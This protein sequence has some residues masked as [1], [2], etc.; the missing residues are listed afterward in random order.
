MKSILTLTWANIKHGRG[1]FKG[2]I[3]LM[4][5]IT[6][7]FAGT[8]SN[9]DRLSESREEKFQQAQVADLMVRLYDEVLTDD[10]L[11]SVEE[12]EYVKK[13]SVEQA[14][15]FQASGRLNGEEKDFWLSV[16]PRK[17]D[18]RVFA[19]DDRHFTDDISLKNG[20]I[21]LPYK[22]KLMKGFEPGA[23]I[24]LK[25]HSGFD[26]KFII[27]GYYEDVVNGATTVGLNYCAI[28]QE[29]F[30]RIKA[31]KT[32]SIYG[33]NCC[34]MLVD[35]VKIDAAD[36]VSSVELRRALGRDTSL[37]SSSIAAYTKENLTDFIEMYSNVGTRTVAIF[38]VLLLSVILIT[39]YNSISASIEMEYTELGILKSQG[40]TAGQISL[41][42][43]FQYTL[44][45]V[46]GGILGIV[47]SVPACYYMIGAWKKITGIMSGTGV[48]FLK[49]G[50]L[51]MG[52]ILICVVFILIAT[53]RIS[54][55]SPVRAISGGS[56]DVH[57]DSR[58]NVRIRKKPM[59]F[60]LALR[61][62]NSRRKSYIGTLF[63]VALLVYF[64][65]SIMILTKG[66]DTEAL[67]YQ[68]EGEISITNKNGLT[69][70][71]IDD[72]QK[73]IQKIDSGASIESE[74]FRYM[75]VDGE[76]TPVH[77]I[78][79]GKEVYKPM[80]G[81]V[82]K[83][84]NEI[85]ITEAVSE[86]IDKEIGDTLTVKYMDKE[87]EFVITGYFQAIWD[88]GL[89]TS[90][91]LDGMERIG[92][93]E[94]SSAYVKLS[95][96]SK[97]DEIIDMLNENYSDKFEATEYQDSEVI[98]SYEKVVNTLMDSIT[99]AMYVVLLTFAVVI[100]NMV[101]KRTFIRER[102]DIGIF[103]AVGFTVDSLRMQ[104][105]VRFTIVAVIGAALGCGLSMVWSRKMLTYILRVVGL[106]DFTTDYS[107]QTFIIPALIV[108]LCFFITSYIASH[109][110]K[111]V[112]VRELIT[113]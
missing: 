37:I 56:S 68:I 64:I 89:V 100:V 72:I 32:D 40:F 75:L 45:L 55:I 65:V 17:D 92:Y 102:T 108:S 24:E 97:R 81:R 63:I 71:N 41:A 90:V 19:D 69:L 20:E 77:Y 5:L 84:D 51:C 33:D 98:Q 60:F 79:A 50:A 91:T 94:I 109:R 25:T 59:A 85:M 46:I 78:R 8:V 6:F 82:P 52:I 54:K 99:I 18:I 49:C 66:L 27:K 10:M 36:G 93:N 101:C 26:E 70:D 53:S 95:D 23:E 58:L 38:V 67:F 107:P 96:I 44:A 76:M 103:K 21:F 4:M 83:Y 1:S 11:K 14:V 105:A 80:K 16:T 35:W 87:T 42:Y 106:T 104:F 29:D 39:M 28:T 9:D 74:S 111:T 73:E 88:F 22:M 2:I 112:E 3:L 61:Q 7:S 47:V 31:E 12:N 62:L 30:D 13:V 43:I 34:A 48:S 113:E 110:V 57:Y 15:F 86:L